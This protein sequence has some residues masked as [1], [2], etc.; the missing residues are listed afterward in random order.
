MWSQ[1]RF[2]ISGR[3]VLERKFLSRFFGFVV[4]AL[5]LNLLP[6][7][8]HPVLAQDFYKDKIIRFIVGQAAGG[9][10]DTSTRA[11][12]SSMLKHNPAN[13]ASTVEH[14]TGAASLA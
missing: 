13:P 10:Y 2:V 14:I 4:I 8:Y 1:R 6:A 11:I 5:G 12:A 3:L 7:H 9:G